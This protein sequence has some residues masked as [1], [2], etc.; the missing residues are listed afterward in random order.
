VSY[1]LEV[2]EDA[3]E[4]I[5]EMTRWWRENVPGKD[6][7][8]EAELLKVEALLTRH[9]E[10]GPAYPRRPGVRRTLLRRTQVY[11]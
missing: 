9:P 5:A 3:R 11:L 8:F 2:S 6:K 10:A 7:L 4:Q 1:R